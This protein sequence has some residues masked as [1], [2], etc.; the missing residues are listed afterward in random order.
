MGKYIYEE[1]K[2]GEVV[3]GLC[4]LCNGIIE[5]TKKCSKCGLD[6]EDKGRMQDYLDNYSP[7]LN[8]SITDMVDGEGPNVC[9]HIFVCPICGISSSVNI[10]KTFI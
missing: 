1:V 9:K 4:P 6:M 8:Y 3:D 2:E 5:Y 7:Y 10:D